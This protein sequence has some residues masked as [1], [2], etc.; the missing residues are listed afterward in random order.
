MSRPPA[1]TSSPATSASAALARLA[2]SRTRL[3]QGLRDRPAGNAELADCLAD[4]KAMPA[5]GLLM[6]LARAWWQKQPLNG[7]VSLLAQSAKAGLAP[8]AKKHPLALVCLGAAAGGLLVWARPWRWGGVLKPALL[9]GLV[10]PLL[11]KA[12]GGAGLE[13]WLAALGQMLQAHGAKTD[14]GTGSTANTPRHSQTTPA[15]GPTAG[16]A[17]T[18]PS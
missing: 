7:V 8:L 12:L 4:L 5:T 14:A 10:Q 9:M 2:L 18:S 1:S 15:S 17:A 3:Q 6:A 13:D 16:V 11:A